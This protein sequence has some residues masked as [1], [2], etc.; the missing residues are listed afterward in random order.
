MR[1]VLSGGEGLTMRALRWLGR[2]L[3]R[4]IWANCA[5]CSKDGP[6]RTIRFDSGRYAVCEG[7]QPKAEEQLRQSRVAAP[8][9]RPRLTVVR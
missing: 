8:D 9:I 3:T 7:C 2:T 6:H 1:E 4:V 5:W